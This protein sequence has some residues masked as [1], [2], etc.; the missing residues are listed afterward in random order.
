ML[1]SMMKQ[2]RR[3][4]H[5]DETSLAHWSRSKGLEITYPDLANVGEVMDAASKDLSCPSLHVQRLTYS[6]GKVWLR[7]STQI[8]VGGS[9]YVSPGGRRGTA[10]PDVS[11]ADLI[12]VVAGNRDPFD[13]LAPGNFWAVRLQGTADPFAHTFFPAKPTPLINKLMV[14]ERLALVLH[15]RQAPLYP[16]DAAR[17]LDTPL[18]SAKG[19][20]A[21]LSREK[22]IIKGK[23]PYTLAEPFMAEEWLRDRYGDNLKTWIDRLLKKPSLLSLDAKQG[24]N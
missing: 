18:A 22:V 13:N 10:E 16:Q 15:C 2:K 19:A 6:D 23:E 5:S 17:L 21:A 9:T 1:P 8:V 3:V 7:Y 11:L 14:S 12:R 4:F 24:V 20:A